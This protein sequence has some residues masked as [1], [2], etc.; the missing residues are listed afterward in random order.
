MAWAI[1]SRSMPDLEYQ[2]KLAPASVFERTHGYTTLQLASPWPQG[3]TRLIQAGA[4]AMLHQPMPNGGN[5]L[6]PLSSICSGAP[7]G[8]SVL[9]TLL[10]AGYTLFPNNKCDTLEQLISECTDTA[11]RVIAGHLSERLRQ[12]SELAANFGIISQNGPFVPDF[13][14]AARWCL[15]LEEL[16]E[17]IDPSIRVP[18]SDDMVTTIYHFPSMPLC[19]FPIFYEHGFAHANIR[20]QRGL[21][22]M[23]VGRRLSFYYYDQ[24]FLTERVPDDK[25]LILH[26][27][28]WL[29][30]HEFLDQKPHGP[31]RLGLNVDA[32]GAHLVAAEMGSH[33]YLRLDDQ[34]D[35]DH[36]VSLSADL[37][38]QFAKDSHRDKC[39]CW[40]NFDGGSCS[41]LKLLYKSQAHPINLRR[42]IAVW[43][44]DEFQIDSTKSLLFDFDM[45]E[46]LTA[47]PTPNIKQQREREQTTNTQPSTR[48]L[49][50]VRLLTFEA[51][52]MTHTCCMFE[53][54]GENHDYIDAILNCN[55][56]TVREIR[57]SEEEIENAALLDTLMGEF[58][59][60]MQQDYQAKSLLDFIFGYWITRIEDLYAVQEDEVQKMQQHVRNVRTGIW[61]RPLRRL[62]WPTDPF[63]FD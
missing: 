37:L 12:L 50:L 7:L 47:S 17:S 11:A 32:A 2:L 3:F 39:V 54:L 33:F 36:Y 35:I 45:F 58:S 31:L 63:T 20:D 23:L 5:L 27:M 52:E 61:P 16:G 26:N 4:G 24:Y 57:Q 38:R 21:P 40:C 51:L 28:P 43:K 9:G 49:E 42:G 15:A 25:T 29:R 56:N 8:P 30:Q 41:P 34:Q 53:K 55:P 6:S 59:T 48:A 19:F 10:G 22:P 14:T 60:A 44:Q 62:L 46:D 1:L 13:A 18:T